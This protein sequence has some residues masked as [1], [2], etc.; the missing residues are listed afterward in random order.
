MNHFPSDDSLQNE[1]EI[2][3]SDLPAEQGSVRQVTSAESSITRISL[4]PHLSLQQRRRRLL[5]T[6]SI[7]VLATV[8]FL[9]SMAPVRTLVATTLFPPSSGAAHSSPLMVPEAGTSLVYLQVLPKW[10]RVLVDGHILSRIPAASFVVP[11]QIPPLQLARGVHTIQWEAEPFNPLRCVVV[12]P[13]PSK[14]ST[15]QVTKSRQNQFTDQA[16]LVGLPVSLADL[17]VSSRTAL[18]QNAQNLLNTFQKTE[19]VQVGERYVV[20]LA[21]TQQSSIQVAQQPLLASLSF[22]L[23]TTADQPAICDGVSLSTAPFSCAIGGQDCRLFCT[24]FWPGATSGWD[25]AAII[26]PQWSYKTLTGQIIAQHQPDTLM[27]QGQ[28][29]F[30]TFHIV[31]HGHWQ[32]TF[33]PTGESTFD[34]PACIAAESDV[35]TNPVLDQAGH[36]DLFWNFLSSSNA[37]DGCVVDGTLSVPSQLLS[38]T[39]ASVEH[40]YLLHRFGVLLAVNAL[41]H[42]T[43]PEIPIASPQ[44]RAIASQILGKQ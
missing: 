32:V 7:V 4:R 36:T 18:M 15:C 25:V 11:G 16:W 28:F 8:V 20:A 38:G 31:W 34:D 1:D 10:G 27:A 35:F 33:H 41:A 21:Q 29:Q 43:W 42:Q 44:E 12:V 37:A 39:P 9:A 22:E 14:S 26:R 13:L 19:T 2:E 23:E 3:V 30:I 6:A 24:L 40:V 17:P 5:F